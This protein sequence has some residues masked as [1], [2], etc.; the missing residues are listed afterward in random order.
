MGTACNCE[1]C[2]DRELE[3]CEVNYEGRADIADIFDC[4]EEWE[5]MIQ[6]RIDEGHCDN[7]SWV[8]DEE[9]NGDSEDYSDCVDDASSEELLDL[10]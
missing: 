1:D 2:N 9:C 8:T 5:T 7:D 6:C 3:E 10:D 4:S